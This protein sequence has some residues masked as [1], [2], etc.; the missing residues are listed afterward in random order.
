MCCMDNDNVAKSFNNLS[1]IIIS[2]NNFT[3]LHNYFNGPKLF[4]IY[5]YLAKFLDTS[6][7][8]FF[9]CRIQKNIFLAF[10]L[11]SLNS[12]KEFIMMIVVPN[13]QQIVIFTKGMSVTFFAG[14]CTKEQLRRR[15]RHSVPYRGQ[16]MKLSEWR[17]FGLEM[18]IYVELQRFYNSR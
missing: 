2:L 18:L 17:R 3:V 14:K 6:A 11:I 7:E 15:N 5:L 13:F 4:L 10:F 9:S 1:I 16:Y 8:S 12:D